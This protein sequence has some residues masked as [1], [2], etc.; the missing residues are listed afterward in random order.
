MTTG[1]FLSELAAIVAF[2]GAAFLFYVLLK[3]LW[4]E[5]GPMLG[6]LFHRGAHAPLDDDRGV[7]NSGSGS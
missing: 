1:G 4:A 5:I 6:L 3:A 7:G 2:V